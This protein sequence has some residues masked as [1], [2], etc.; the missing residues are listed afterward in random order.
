MPFS[1]LA[2]KAISEK[3]TNELLESMD[4]DRDGKLTV[5]EL[6]EGTFGAPMPDDVKLP[7]PT[8]EEKADEERIKKEKE[9][10]KEKFKVA[11]KNKDGFLD[12]DELPAAF[13]PE[14]HEGVLALTAAAALKARDTDGD[15]ELSPAEFWHGED[16]DD[17][18][19]E[20]L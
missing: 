20:E 3:E 17:H 1:D 8:A 2:K 5:D 6:I 13:Y 18:D 15:G 10:E 4:T 11:D 7:E 12:K 14:T 16:P 9:L 19:N